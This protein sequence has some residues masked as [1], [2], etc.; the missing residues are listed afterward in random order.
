MLAA[1]LVFTLLSG[2]G[3]QI[4]TLSKT[5]T[6]QA[7]PSLHFSDSSFGLDDTFALLSSNR[8]SQQ[9]GLSPGAMLL[10]LSPELLVLNEREILR[11]G[12]VNGMQFEPVSNSSGEARFLSRPPT[13]STSMERFDTQSGAVAQEG[14]IPPGY[15][16]AP[17]TGLFFAHAGVP[18]CLGAS[19]S[20]PSAYRYDASL[21][22]WV[23]IADLPVL[24]EQR[25]A[26]STAPNKFTLITLLL[27]ETRFDE[28]DPALDQWNLKA[29]IPNLS[30][31]TQAARHRLNLL[32]N[33]KIAYRALRALPT[34]GIGTYLYDPASGAVETLPNPPEN[35]RFTD[36]TFA[37]LNGVIIPE[38]NGDF[39]LAG[40][41]SSDGTLLS[42]ETVRWVSADS[43]WEP[44]PN[45]PLKSLLAHAIP[46]PNGNT[47]LFDMKS[48]SFEYLANTKSFSVPVKVPGI[49][50]ISTNFG[51]YPQWRS[52]AAVLPDGSVWI[53]PQ[54]TAGAFFVYRNGGW[55]LKN[56]YPDYPLMAQTNLV[57]VD[58]NAKKMLWS[59]DTQISVLQSEDLTTRKITPIP[60]LQPHER[61]AK[62]VQF[63]ETEALLYV[64]LVH[65]DPTASY[66]AQFTNQKSNSRA[67]IV[68]IATGALTPI[69]DRPHNSSSPISYSFAQRYVL[70]YSG[71]T[72]INSVWNYAIPFE[73]YD[74]VTN[75]WTSIPRPV[76]AAKAPS[77]AYDKDEHAL[78]FFG[79][80][81]PGGT[82]NTTHVDRYDLASAT[83]TSLS[84]PH[85]A[86]A[87][88]APALSLSG[89]KFLLIGANAGAH[90]IIDVANQTST[91]STGNGLPTIFAHSA[92][93]SVALQRSPGIRF[94][95]GRV[96][97]PLCSSLNICAEIGVYDPD[98]NTWTTV[99]RFSVPFISSSIGQ[100]GGSIL[101]CSIPAGVVTKS[102]LTISP[103]TRGPP[104]IPPPR[105]PTNQRFMIRTRF[106]PP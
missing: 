88:G 44:G 105:P 60:F 98:S 11:F 80:E 82:A 46:L 92:S 58:L 14:A 41:L 9:G 96:A 94:A 13:A 1:A 84:I 103:K 48:N 61:Q 53:T 39:L 89:G 36:V 50:P 104:P 10:P 30:G 28:Y 54:L 91:E 25:L 15:L 67:S 17:A 34:G 29:T 16:P 2:C 66:Y 18:Y 26:F 55:S 100:M 6:I 75:S 81:T 73:L 69:P 78:Y 95:D 62:A 37:S 65:D 12:A 77:V 102:T 83:W 68:R 49:N 64:D 19:S 72:Y 31:D 59:A 45:L 22:E 56:I 47:L 21:R 76:H 8:T 79:G 86:K 38:A 97:I 101:S 99:P 23:R 51:S 5:Q 35:T 40:R 52:K 71:R 3:I 32:S 93:S 27:T 63:S 106:T 70:L 90:W 4:R 24:G 7:P 57:G 74:R 33:G 42:E 85:N 87:G 20:D 43:A